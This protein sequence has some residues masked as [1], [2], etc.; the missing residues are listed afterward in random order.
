MAIQRID[1]SKLLE[2]LFLEE[3]S[4]VIKVVFTDNPIFQ[5]KVGDVFFE[6]TQ[7][8]MAV[9]SD[10]SAIQD[11]VVHL[12][13]GGL[14]GTPLPAMVLINDKWTLKQWNAEKEILKRLPTHTDVPSWFFVP[15]S[16]R[17]F[18]KEADFPNGTLFYLCYEPN[19]TDL[20]RCVEMLFDRYAFLKSKTRQERVEICCAALESYSQDLL[21]CDMHFERMEKGRFSFAEA[22]SGSPEINAFSVVDAIAQGQ[23]HLIE[24]RLQQC[25][26]G[27]Q[28]AL[29]IFMAL[30]YFMKQLVAVQA[31]FAETKNMRS[32][33]DMAKI[34]FPAQKR[35]EKALKH[36]DSV[37]VI[38]FFAAASKIEMELKIQK[39]P[40]HF[41]AVEVLSW[42]S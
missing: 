4:S 7:E 36:I 15:L 29:S 6:K 12:S 20:M 13:E 24:L 9:F 10:K 27:G 2:L 26:D 37:K 28:D 34:P 32:A 38:S 8:R 17:N 23:T 19:E 30:A 22:L 16:S 21:S 5:K 33:F 41:L 42:L 3:N 14:F 11:Y 1:N 25:A 35:L 40:H 31:A 39:Y 18:F